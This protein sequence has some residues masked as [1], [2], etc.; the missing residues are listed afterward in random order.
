[1]D[2]AHV[3]DLVT[4]SVVFHETCFIITESVFIVHQ[5]YVVNNKYQ[6]DFA[7]M[8][9][10]LYRFNFER[11]TSQSL[12]LKVNPPSGMWTNLSLLSCLAYRLTTSCIIFATLIIFLLFAIVSFVIKT[13][14][15]KS[16]SRTL[17]GVH[18]PE[19]CSRRSFAVVR[20]IC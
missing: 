20:C 10:A 1:M 8:S 3:N 17:L 19:S 2:Q 5:H 18:I 16:S 9:L 14:R 7:A 12:V 13:G 6:H 11:R 4:W 15:D